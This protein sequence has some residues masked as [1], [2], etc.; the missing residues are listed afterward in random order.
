MRDEGILKLMTRREW[1][2]LPLAT[3][4]RAQNAGM[5]SR[6]VKAA[7]RGK[8]SGLPF[9]ARFTNVAKQAGLRSPV[10]Y[11]EAA[12]DDYILDSVGCGVAFP[13]HQPSQHPFSGISAAGRVSCRWP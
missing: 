10:I 5:G 13:R 1:L 6:R 11:G 12:N 8:P 9:Q 3:L 4:A 7:P 2:A